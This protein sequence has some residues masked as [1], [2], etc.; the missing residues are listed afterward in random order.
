MDAAVAGHAFWL[1]PVAMDLTQR[2]A[3]GTELKG[4]D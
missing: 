1:I 2:N 3:E 4:S